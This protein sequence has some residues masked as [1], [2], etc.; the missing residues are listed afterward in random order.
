MMEGINQGGQTQGAVL[1]P[2]QGTYTGP[3]SD[4]CPEVNLHKAEI[5]IEANHM[6]IKENLMTDMSRIYGT[7]RNIYYV[8]NVAKKGT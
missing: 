5:D 8:I 2:I 1:P 6:K 7:I 3:S 4:N